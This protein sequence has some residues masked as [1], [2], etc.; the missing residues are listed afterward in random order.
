MEVAWR[1]G[2]T[3]LIER[4]ANALE[5]YITDEPL[6]WAQ[7]YIMWGR[8]LAAHQRKPNNET[9]EGL[10]L[11]KDEAERLELLASIPRLD[12]ALKNH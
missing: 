2:D 8:A 3:E 6:P 12:Q 1:Y 9:T 4:Y 5:E 10:R 11:V 7:Y